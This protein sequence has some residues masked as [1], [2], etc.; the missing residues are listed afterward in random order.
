MPKKN[1]FSVITPVFNG[2]K[3]LEELI[4]SVKSQTYIR[5]I[6]HIIINDGSNDDGATQN[7][8]DQYPHLRSLSRG[9]LG[10]YTSIN[11]GLR[12]ATGDFVVVISAD[13]LFADDDV[14]KN[15]CAA[16]KKNKNI[17][18]VYGRSSRIN[19][20]GDFLEYDGIV[21]KEPFKKWRFKY[22][23]PLLHCSAFVRRSFLLNN[24]LY[25]DNINFKYAADWDWV[26]RM[27][28]LTDFFFIDLAISKY[29]VHTNQTTNMVQRNILNKED[30]RVLRK[31]KSSI[32]IYYL[33]KNLGR[34]H[35]TY[36][37][38]KIQGF[39]V[40]FNKVLKFLKS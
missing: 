35:K 15:V 18:V 1:F 12:I 30:I 21:I 25:F 37:I 10:Q 16:L 28:K 14:F 40:L 17:N 39:R 7:I 34:L 19:E 2:S 13:D 36:V 3:Y 9:N 8:I 5:Y 20:S 11:E 6:E 26:L 29:R 33:L 31:N 27:S 4:L 22:Q 38:L 32:L 23:L 24:N